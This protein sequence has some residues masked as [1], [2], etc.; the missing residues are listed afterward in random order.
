MQRRCCRP[1]LKKTMTFQTGRRSP[2]LM[3]IVIVIRTPSGLVLRVAPGRS[4]LAQSQRIWV[5][6]CR[7]AILQLIQRLQLVT[8]ETLKRILRPEILRGKGRAEAMT[9][10]RFSSKKISQRWV[11]SMGLMKS[12]DQKLLTVGKCSRQKSLKRTGVS[13]R[14][15]Q[16]LRRKNERIPDLD[17]SRRRGKLIALTTELSS[18]TVSNRPRDKASLTHRRSPPV[19]TTWR[20]GRT[21]S[22]LRGTWVLSSAGSR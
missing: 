8:E 3:G 19:R 13:I 5:D 16:R 14:I 11:P 17:S 15:H 22:V 20:S 12:R 10:I 6:Q 7:E 18:R 1:L 4:L 21:I 9:A 2:V